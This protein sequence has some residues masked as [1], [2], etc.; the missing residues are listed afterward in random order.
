MT[1]S[2]LRPKSDAAANNPQP[3]G[4]GASVQVERARARRRLVGALVLLAVG[5]VTFPLLFETQPRP[6]GV[7]T[8]INVVQRDGTPGAT[9]P[10]SPAVSNK[11]V[12]PVLH[13][14]VEEVP[15]AAGDAASSAQSAV[16]SSVSAPM[17]A[18]PLTAAPVP[19]IAAPTKPDEV[20]AAKPIAK[21]ASAPVSKPPTRDKPPADKPAVA[22]ASPEPTAPKPGDA[23]IPP[24]RY[25][26]QVGAFIDDKPVRETRLKVEGLGLKTYTQV[27]END[28]GKRTRVRVGPFDTKAEADAAAKKL[29]AA[30]LP[31]DLLKL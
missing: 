29:K 11:P 14:D 16:A 23:A 26:V 31:A 10:T 13:V 28:A 25:V 12:L 24:V 21:A 9:A 15:V 30:G 17:T 3:M 5:V 19:A 8:P 6:I 18:A 2:F 20:A 4:E 27:I 1:W 7:D 22:A